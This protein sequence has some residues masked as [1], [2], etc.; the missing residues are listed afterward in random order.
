MPCV[1]LQ[2]VKFILT[3]IEEISDRTFDADCAVVCHPLLFVILRIPLGQGR[4]IIGCKRIPVQFL[5]IRLI[6]SANI[7][8]FM[9]ANIIRNKCLMDYYDLTGYM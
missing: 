5:C 3:V 9:V 8:K 1:F 6:Q 2:S 4:N 7:V